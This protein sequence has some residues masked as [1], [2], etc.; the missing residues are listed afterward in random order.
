MV[1]LTYDK[2][3][4]FI[5]YS[6]HYFITKASLYRSCQILIMILSEN[7]KIQFQ[8]EFR[9]IYKNNGYIKLTI[10]YQSYP[11]IG[12]RLSATKNSQP[13]ALLTCS[14]EKSELISVNIRPL[15]PFTSKTPWND[16]SLN[17]YHELFIITYSIIWI[18]L[19]PINVLYRIRTISVI[20]MLTQFF[21]VNGSEHFSNILCPPPLAVCSIVTI[22]FDPGAETRSIAPP[23]PFTIFPG[24]I[25]FAKSPN[26]ET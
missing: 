14:S 3:F 24:I 19:V 16:T 17:L 12:I 20:T 22:T 18:F 5:S 25:Q 26:L 4:M 7:H 21:P 9:N 2:I 13:V 1:F 15:S 10:Y 8:I 6:L 11:C 23:I